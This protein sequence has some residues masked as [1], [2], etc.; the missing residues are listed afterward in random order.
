MQRHARLRWLEIKTGDAQMA[1]AESVSYPEIVW[2][3]T[4]PAKREPLGR[5]H[6]AAGLGDEVSPVR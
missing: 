2:I 3:S 6:E 4:W 1:V 5:L